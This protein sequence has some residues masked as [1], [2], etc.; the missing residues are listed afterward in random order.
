MGVEQLDRRPGLAAPPIAPVLVACVVLA[1]LSLLLPS[2]L[3][4]D[5]LTWA[6]WAREIVHLRLDTNGGPAWKPLPV[7]ID[8]VFAP[9]GAVQQWV[10]L[11]VA[12]AGGLLAVAMAFRLAR[13]LAGQWAG[14]LAATGMLLSDAFLDY[15]MPLGMSEPLLAGLSLLAVERHLDGRYAQA[16]GL[17]FVCLLIRPEAFPFFVGYSVFLWTRIPRSRPWT[18]VLAAL[19]PV[20]WLLPDYL[21][22][23]DWLRSTRR[24]AAPT[25][26][27][28][29]LTSFPAGSVVLSAFNAAIAPVAVGAAIAVSFAVVGYVTRRQD[30][31][32]VALSLV[33]F[34]WLVEVALTTQARMGSGD[35]RYLIVFVALGCVLAAVGWTRLV[36]VTSTALSRRAP[37]QRRLAVRIGVVAA[38]LLASA[39]FVVQ[40]LAE[41]SDKAGDIPFWTHKNGELATLIGRAGGRDQILRCAPVTADIYQMPTVAWELRI[42]QSQIV[43]AP[44]P[45]GT[46]TK[47]KELPTPTA[48]TVFRTRTTRAGPMLPAEVGPSFR[49]V[50]VTHQWQ[51]LNTCG[52]NPPSG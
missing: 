32:L 5:P 31:T 41:L 44:G 21:S 20:L 6:T 2:T 19:L 40:R 50:A 16:Y 37:P 1:T 26:G 25:Q 4:F 42:H 52:A 3:T 48:G 38:A 29:L 9:L 28:P 17:I 24:A 35:E 33:Y 46:V 39:P 36:N 49:I 7:L 18:V 14:V 45:K 27:G 22:T 51:I 15:L 43:I 30:R 12:R 47:G 10:W 13:R 23:G 8:S 11:V 34:G